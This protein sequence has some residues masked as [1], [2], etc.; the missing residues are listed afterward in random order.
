MEIVNRSSGGKKHGSFYSECSKKTNKIVFV[1][2]EYENQGGSIAVAL[3]SNAHERPSGA[4]GC[5]A[6]EATGE[7]TKESRR[8]FGTYV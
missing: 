2:L 8:S 3:V 7:M 5:F 6:C 1:F 4:P